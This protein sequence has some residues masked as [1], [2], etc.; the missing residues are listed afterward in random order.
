MSILPLSAQRRVIQRTRHTLL[1]VVE[2]MLMVVEMTITR[3]KMKMIIMRMMRWR[4]NQGCR[5]D[6]SYGLL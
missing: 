4:R 1:M 3:R 5:I 2:M 6:L